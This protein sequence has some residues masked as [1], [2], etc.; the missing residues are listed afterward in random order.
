MPRRDAQTTHSEP[1]GAVAAPPAAG[2][3]AEGLLAGLNEAQR[4][5]VT[6][7]EGPLLI[8][9]GAGSGKTRVLTH[10]VAHLIAA[11][12]VHPRGI[13]AVT[14]TNKAAQEMR[15]RVAA[16]VGPESKAIWVGTFHA[17][18]S[19]LLRE[20]GDRLGLARDFAVYDD[21]DQLALVRDALLQLRL[22]DKRFAPR[23]MLNMISRAKEKMVP[24]EEWRD[25]YRGFVEDMCG[26][27]Y[28]I[29]QARLKQSNALDF[30]DLLMEAVRLLQEHPDVLARYQDRFRYLMVDEY[31]DV[32]YVQ[33][34][35]LKLLAA[36]HRNLCVVGD[37][38]Q[39]IYAF[40]GADVALMLQF[41][42]DYADARVVKLEQNYRSTQTILTAAHGVV[43]RN[44]GRKD[45][46]LWTQNE[47][48]SPVRL[49]EAANEQE[50]AVFVVERIRDALRA[51][52]RQLGEFAVLYRT[53]A[54]SRAFEDVFVN[55]AVPYRIVGGVRFYERREVK[56]VLAYLRVLQNPLD[57]VSLKR[58]LNVP[59]RGIGAGTLQV[60]E[61]QAAGMNVPLWD[62]LCEAHRLEALAPRARR[63]VT[64]FAALI[65]GLR[66]LPGSA[67]VTQL[68]Q[69]VIERTG[70][71][72]ALE[73]DRT[74]ESQSR[75]ENVREL[76][77][78]TTAF[79]ATA[80]ERSLAVFLEQVSLVSDLDTV[81]MASDAV[82]LMTLHSAK[83]LEFPTVFLVG[84]EDGV[85]P[86][87]R[88]MNSQRELEEERRL[89]YVG[90]TRAREELV[91]THAYRRTL[92]GAVSNNAPSRF[93]REIP[94]EV[95]G[96]GRAEPP[97]P[98]S[99]RGN[100]RRDWTSW[101][102]QSSLAARPPADAGAP[103]RAGQKVRH[104]RFGT[105]VVLSVRP[106][107]GDFQ[108]SVAFPDVGVKKLM[109]SIARLDPV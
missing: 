73:Q 14:F 17:T 78:V 31:Q 97:Q 109:H 46:K 52:R 91:L 50:E 76:L 16:L 27:V 87:I 59:A 21:G 56:D 42:R 49:V 8:F 67:S 107:S 19:R 71:L 64:A 90:I 98:P 7:T 22:D 108:V 85:F 70:Y 72:S 38:D 3:P 55:F 61:E 53:N 18:C 80:E 47:A 66:E 102:R 60:L 37:D 23:A 75:A 63:A 93:L 86:H 39:S 79:D 89:C 30:D 100:P 15:E 95:F 35:L 106:E 28:E 13:L 88:S 29:Y 41:E 2:R 92:F 6:H 48:G 105:G 81:D 10:R 12:G 34:M 62:A 99:P 40:R 96:P 11:R 65:L 43:S 104:P 84:M 83:G 54:Q 45:K 4:A 25:H 20:S 5:A 101:D 33:Y 24:P 103:L 69:A 68:A 32:N 94:P 58:I 77:T 9:A 36:E 57:G 1:A 51:G 82:T 74:P 26:Q 44:Q